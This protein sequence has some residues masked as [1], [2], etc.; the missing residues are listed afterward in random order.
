MLGKETRVSAVQDVHFRIRK[1][2]VV[3]S[4][5]GAI[6]RA[7]MAS[8]QGSTV[9]RVLAVEDEKSSPVHWS[10]EELVCK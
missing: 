3:L 6:L 5:H 10:L 9:G 2:G 8:H 7:N 4:I 1:L